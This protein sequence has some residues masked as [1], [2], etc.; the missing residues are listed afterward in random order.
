M[1]DP[2]NRFAALEE[3]LLWAM[4]L[5]VG[6]PIALILNSGLQY[7]G[8]ASGFSGLDRLISLLIGGGI[9]ALF[10]LFYLAP[11]VRSK[12]LWVLVTS[13][14]WVFG[15]GITWILLQAGDSFFRF[16]FSMVGSNL[17]GLTPG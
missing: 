3:W 14:G 10:Q 13:L 6:W 11:D 1:K 17:L 16:G 8:L 15:A 9:I 4:I 12:R 5:G 7:F 2:V